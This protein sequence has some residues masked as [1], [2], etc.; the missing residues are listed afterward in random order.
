MAV[1]KN[2][3]ARRGASRMAKLAARAC[4]DRAFLGYALHQYQERYGLS[5]AALRR[6]LGIHRDMLD[7]LRLCR[8][9]RRNRLLQDCLMIAWESGCETSALTRIVCEMVYTRR[10]RGQGKAPAPHG[11]DA[12]QPGPQA[13]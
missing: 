6:E 3:G 7:E 5:D 4:A 10:T 9:P 11:D 8:M 13:S 1:E 2:Q 12:P